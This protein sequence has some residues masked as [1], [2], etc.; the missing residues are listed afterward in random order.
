MI[1]RR[2][3]IEGLYVIELERHQDR[4]G[5]FAR[6]FCEDEFRE[7]GLNTYWPQCN[8]SHSNLQ[9]T[10]RGI[11]YQSEPEPDAK[12]I[13]VTRG[14]I[15]CAAVDLRL[16][17]GNFGRR[18]IW[19]L[20]SED[21]VMLYVPAGCGFGFQTLSDDTEISYQMSVRYRPNLTRGVRWN[22]PDLDIC[23]PL[24]PTSI[25]EADATWPLMADLVA[26]IH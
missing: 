2:M 4:R 22:D 9:G 19:N 26:A 18:L 17:G 7:H 23:W 10:V 5:F 8:M 14:R 21:G 6:T 15:F 3:S 16:D 13:R 20:D 25:S 12:L 24:V 1:F 11:H